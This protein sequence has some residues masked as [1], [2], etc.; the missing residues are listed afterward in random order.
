MEYLEDHLK[1]YSECINAISKRMRKNLKDHPLKFAR[2]LSEAVQ[3][4]KNRKEFSEIID[5][6][7]TL[8]M[9]KAHDF[10]GWM[11][12]S[13]SIGAC[14]GAIYRSLNYMQVPIKDRSGRIHDAATGFGVH[15]EH[16]IPINQIISALW[17]RRDLFLELEN[18]TIVTRTAHEEFIKLS[19]CTAI[20]RQE[21]K[22]CIKPAY[23][24]RHP[25]F[26]A[27]G[28][29]KIGFS[30]KDVRPFIRYDFTGGLKIFEMINGR[31]IKP[32]TWSL[33]DHEDLIS[34]IDVYHWDRISKCD[35]A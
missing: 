33:Q 11:A 26:D 32:D 3:T 29:P 24:K 2:L 35:F 7:S 8:A 25:D 15:I 9:R 6:K 31:E 27:T 22:N 18:P 17:S 19:V 12:K 30:L 20:T 13:G 23:A 21:Q 16:S 5:N 34:K 1:D 10:F 14:K 28:R 4:S